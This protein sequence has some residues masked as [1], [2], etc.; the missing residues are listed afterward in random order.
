MTI[1]LTII[2]TDVADALAIAAWVEEGRRRSEIARRPPFSEGVHSLRYGQIERPPQLLADRLVAHQS[3][4]LRRARPAG[5]RQA[6]PRRC[7]CGPG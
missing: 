1:A 3:H 5:P 6:H 2:T 7:G 4:G